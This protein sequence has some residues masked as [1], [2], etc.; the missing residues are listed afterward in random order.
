MCL[1]FVE[2]AEVVEIRTPVDLVVCS[3]STTA[4]SWARKGDPLAGYKSVEMR[5]MVELANALNKEVELLRRLCTSFEMF[6]I[7]GLDNSDTDRLSRLLYRPAQGGA[8]GQLLCFTFALTRVNPPSS[9]LLSL[10][11]VILYH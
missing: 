6:H 8:L 9:F 7:P 3:D 11:C 4:V 5:A 1:E 2:S 10:F